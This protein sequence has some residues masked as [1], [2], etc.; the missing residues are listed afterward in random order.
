MEICSVKT[1]IA[2]VRGNNTENNLKP[3]TCPEAKRTTF[4]QDYQVDMGTNRIGGPISR[5]RRARGLVRSGCLLPCFTSKPRDEASGAGE[6]S[7]RRGDRKVRAR[8]T[9]DGW[10]REVHSQLL[11]SK[12]TEWLMSRRY[13]GGWGQIKEIG[14]WNVAFRGWWSP[15]RIHLFGQEVASNLE[16]SCSI[17]T[18][19]HTTH[20]LT[21]WLS[22]NPE[23]GNF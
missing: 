2:E 22:P 10:R 6:E 16:S 12:D 8:I 13:L 7:Y 15:E 20:W 14:A 1:R 21:V 18:S 4:S 23:W 9:K 3:F 5:S 19:S 11:N 17:W